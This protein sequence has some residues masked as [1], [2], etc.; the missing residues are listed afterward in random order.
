MKKGDR[1]KLSKPRR[2]GLANAVRGKLVG[3]IQVS[4]PKAGVNYGRTHMIKIKNEAEYIAK[5]LTISTGS[6]LTLN[7]LSDIFLAPAAGFL[8]A[9]VASLGQM[10]TDGTG[11]PTQD[12]IVDVLKNGTSIF[13]G[14]T[15]INFSHA[16]QVGTANTPISADNYGALSST[17]VAIKKGDKIQ[18]KITQVLN[19]TSPVQGQDL[20]VTIVLARGNGWAPEATLLGQL[21]ELDQ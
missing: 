7:A 11:A 12:F 15:K 16:L 18:V 4:S 9:I 20:G 17:P 8:K 19:G 3:L 2:L 13:S 21:S 6:A 14:S 10:G 1:A 5:Q